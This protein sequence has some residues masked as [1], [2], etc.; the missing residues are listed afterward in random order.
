MNSSLE[1]ALP[2]V[3]NNPRLRYICACAQ[4]DLEL[5]CHE[6]RFYVTPDG[7]SGA[8]RALID[9]TN[10]LYLLGRASSEVVDWVLQFHART[11]QSGRIG[12][13]V[14]G[15]RRPCSVW[16]L[17]IAWIQRGMV[18]VLDAAAPIWRLSVEQPLAT[19]RL[20]RQ[21]KGKPLG[22][23]DEANGRK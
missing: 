5:E 3:G 20:C 19:D 13:A 23:P 2:L 21:L 15:V 4:R 17:R 12:S 22:S 14:G 7:E 11:S 8:L 6:R 18:G 9:R 1:Q 16:A 10:M